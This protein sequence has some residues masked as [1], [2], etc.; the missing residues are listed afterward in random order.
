VK[1]GVSVAVCLWTCGL[2]ALRAQTLEVTPQ[3]LLADE[4]A[5]IRAAGL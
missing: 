4:S 1:L 5:T 3:R 2:G